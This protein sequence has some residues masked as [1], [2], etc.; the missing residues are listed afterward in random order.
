MIDSHHE[1]TRKIYEAQHDRLVADQ[2]A[3]KRINSLVESNCFGVEEAWF[4][5]KTAI[6]VGCGNVG[7]LL[8]RF[9]KLGVDKMVGIDIGEGW[10]NKLRSV[11]ISNGISEEKFTLAKGSALDIPFKDKS[12]DFVAIN[13]VLIHLQDI[14]E[15]LRGFNEGARI[16]KPGGY[17]Y[18]GYGPCQGLVQGAIFPAIRKYYSENAEFRELIDTISPQIIHRVIDKITS[19]AKKYT[20][21]DLNGTF[22]KSLFGEDFCVFLQNFIQAPTWLS[23]E[24]TPELIEQFY[25]ANGFSNVKRVSNYTKRTDVRKYFAPLHYDRDY[26]FSRILYG[27]GY[28]QYIG[29]KL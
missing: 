22:L 27:K 4:K 5:G 26:D 10:I 19:D 16:V 12:F 15:V 3:F 25:R 6:D 9:E 8:L 23:N 2:T 20:G 17:L 29:Q 11:L 13:G 1:K 28:V 7:A 21:E 24:C 14:A 18:T